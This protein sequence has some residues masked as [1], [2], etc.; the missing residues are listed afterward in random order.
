MMIALLT[1][2]NAANYG[3]ALQAYA[4]QKFLLNHSVDCK[5]IDY[6]NKARKNSYSMFNHISREIGNGNV[7][8]ALKYTVGSPFMMLRK[9][10]F[11]RFYKY[12]L[13]CT[14]KRYETP[15]QAKELNGVFDKFIVGSD[16]VWNLKNNGNDY[17]FLLSFVDDNAKKI[18]YSS[19]FGLATIPPQ[20]QEKYAKYLSQINSIA[21]RES[22]GAKLVNDLTGRQA[23]LVLDP[24]FLLSKEQWREVANKEQIKEKY[25]FYYTNKGGQREQ[26]IR[27]TGYSVSDGK[28]YLLSRNISPNDFLCSK[29]RVKYTMS[30]EEFIRVIR[31]AELIVSAS[32][33]CISMAIILNKPFI[34]ILTGD[35]GKD[36]RVLNI[37]QLLGLEERILTSETTLE[38]V[39]TLINYNK[40]N[41]RITELVFDSSKY[42]FDSIKN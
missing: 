17:A 39:N 38:T 6:V 21:V 2:H 10:R 42:L 26:F 5:Y 32:F 16:Q 1:F 15:E 19:S 31:D 7:I 33:H 3:A 9:W 18:S 4:L 22:F 37:L 41:T 27:Q 14:A 35:K 8:S 25:T 23:K 11:S 34:A 30:P 29:A 24:V 40:I 36:E 13:I 28:D 20:E 12:N